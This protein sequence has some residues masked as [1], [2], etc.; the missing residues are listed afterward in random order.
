[1]Y[2]MKICD[3]IIIFL[4]GYFIDYYHII[5]MLII[6]FIF[7]YKNDKDIDNDIEKK[8]HFAIINH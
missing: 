6:F 4:A 2:R 3:I 8:Y 5:Y 7:T 1:M